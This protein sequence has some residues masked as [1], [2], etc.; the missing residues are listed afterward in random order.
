MAQAKRI[1][2]E[3]SIS[4]KAVLVGLLLVP[5]H[6][7]WL[8]IGWGTGGY[9]TAQSFPT[10]IALYFNVI[11]TLLLMIL[12][13]RSAG[14][15]WAPLR[16]S[17]NDLL[18]IFFILSL[19]SSIAGHDT[20]QILWPLLSYAIWFATP[21]N[22]WA[23][24]FH[25]HIPGWMAPK[26][27]EL[28]ADL[29]EGGSTLY[30]WD[31][32]RPLLE[33]VLWWSALI[34]AVC[35]ALLGLTVIVRRA[36]TQREKL[37]YPI[38]QIPLAMTE[39]GGRGLFSKPVFW[40]GFLLAGGVDLLNGL[41]HLYPAVPSLGGTRSLGIAFDQKPFDAMGYLSLGIYPFAVGLSFFIPLDLSFSIW[42]FFLFGRLLRVLGS[43][44]GVGQMPGFP[45]L[46]AQSFGA[47]LMLGL[48][49]LYTLRRGVWDSIR[50]VLRNAEGSAEQRVTRWAWLCLGGGVGF[51]LF[52]FL[53]AGAKFWPTVLY[54]LLFFLLSLTLSRVR[55]EVGPPSHDIPWQPARTL[56]WFF[57][58]RPLGAQTLTA[59][60]F[61]HGFNRS[62]RCHPM[63]V[64]LEGF[65][66][67]ELRRWQPTTL[68]ALLA[69]T[70]VLATVASAWAYYDQAYRYGAGVYGEQ[71]QCRWTFDELAS[72]LSASHDPSKPDV[73]ASLL[74]MVGTALLALAR[75]RFLWWPFHPAGYALSLSYWNTSWY[76]FSIFLGWAMKFVLFRVGGLPLYRNA[77]PFFA[78]LVLGEFTAGAGWSLLGTFLGRSMYRIMW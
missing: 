53:R 14:R 7:Y 38:L 39:N 46:V 45:F 3:R 64:M 37:S 71:A 29:F 21:E 63:P 4:R 59:F 49:A 25:H 41:N 50:G 67:A 1:S 47:W 30:R 12:W 34:V 74:A 68:A 17:D 6:A 22:N 78:G 18:V 58:T 66:A 24:L 44:G 56:V 35:L 57:G 2:L 13:N 5:P 51:S 36:W 76:W 72:W 48:F 19:A 8:M 31:H 52:F 23:E 11:F 40:I 27:R 61:F 65:K 43:V 77:I 42:F 20:L 75:R 69:V 16:F 10:V 9:G 26:D 28:L 33:P 55:A 73:V 62:Y 70:V 32:L 54:F 15:L 60:S